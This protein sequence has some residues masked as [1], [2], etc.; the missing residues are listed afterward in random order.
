RGEIRDAGQG[1]LCIRCPSLAKNVASP[2][3]TRDEVVL[4]PGGEVIFLSRLNDLIKVGGISVYP[5]EIEAGARLHPAVAD[6][7]VL[8]RPDPIYE[9]VFDLIV[10]GTESVTSEP[11]IRAFLQERLGRPQ[12]PSRILVL[13]ELPRSTLGKIDRHRV[14]EKIARSDAGMDSGD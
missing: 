11:E 13:D 2:L 5:K 1:Q 7:I 10:E 4:S 8:R 12:W 3:V 9:E 6:C 14:L